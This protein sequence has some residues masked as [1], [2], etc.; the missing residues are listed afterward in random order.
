M[1]A[2]IDTNVLVSALV[3]RSGPPAKIRDAWLAGKIVP[4]VSR[5]TTQELLRVLHYPKFALTE[6]DRQ[7]LLATYLPHCETLAEPR[8]RKRLPECRDPDDQPFLLLAVAAGVDALITGDEDLAHLAGVSG[9]KI[10]SPAALIQRLQGGES[11]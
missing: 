8:T 1:R 9:V 5:A 7:T 6:A 2:V 4:V 11:N 3:F 10:V